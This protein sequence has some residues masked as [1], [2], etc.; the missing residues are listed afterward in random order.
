MHT[1]NPASVFRAAPHR[2]CGACTERPARRGPD[3]DPTLLQALAA[4]EH[5]ERI[6]DFV[7][8]GH[9][10]AA[11]L[12]DAQGALLAAPVRSPR[13]PGSAG[14]IDLASA[15]LLEP[16]WTAVRDIYA[17][18]EAGQRSPATSV[19]RHEV[20]GGQLSNLR[21]Q[22]EAIGVGDRFADVLE[23]YHDAAGYRD[24]VLSLFSLNHVTLVQRVLAEHPRLRLDL[25]V[26]ELPAAE[27]ERTDVELLVAPR[28]FVAP[29]GF[30]SRRL[31]DEHLARGQHR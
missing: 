8:V 31:M 6:T 26:R 1:Q 28:D 30:R 13:D 20:P 17:P 3:R 14:G 25:S 15:A 12:I 10:A 9:G 23:A 22:A 16:Y 4:A 19:Y 21:A 24:E 29:P 27:D 18:F 7:P 5:P 11:A 2:S